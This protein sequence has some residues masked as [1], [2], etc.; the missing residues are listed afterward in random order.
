MCF[1][2]FNLNWKRL[3]YQLIDKLEHT[4]GHGLV[5]CHCLDLKLDQP[6]CHVSRLVVGETELGHLGVTHVANRK[7]IFATWHEK[8]L[9]EIYFILKDV[10]V[11]QCWVDEIRLGDHS[12]IENGQV[13]A[14]LFSS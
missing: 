11:K 12:Q 7:H 10:L 14:Y 4:N 13:Y 5:R 3:F 9:Y 1:S 8:Q 2:R 6:L